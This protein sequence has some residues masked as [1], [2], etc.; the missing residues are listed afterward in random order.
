MNEISLK[1]LNFTMN[2][3]LTMPKRAKITGFRIRRTPINCKSK[4]D[5]VQINWINSLVLNITSIT[6]PR[7]ACSSCK[8]D[9]RHEINVLKNLKNIVRVYLKVFIALE[10]YLLVWMHQIW[11]CHYNCKR[12]DILHQ[13]TQEQPEIQINHFPTIMNHK[14]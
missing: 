1:K 3:I 6:M 8:W 10:Y 9:T 5:L 4:V 11:L 12:Y 2:L 13:D 7:Y 14:W